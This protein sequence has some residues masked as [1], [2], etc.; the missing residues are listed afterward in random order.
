MH[1]QRLGLGSEQAG[2]PGWPRLDG[3]SQSQKR[4]VGD[5]IRPRPPAQRHLIFEKIKSGP[6]MVPPVQREMSYA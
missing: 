3:D 1:H 2:R 4:K 6:K 5:A